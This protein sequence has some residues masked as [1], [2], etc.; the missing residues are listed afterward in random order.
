[1]PAILEPAAVSR[2]LDP[3]AAGAEPLLALLRPYAAE[4]L[5]VYPVSPRVNQVTYDQPDCVIA[6]PEEGNLS[7]FP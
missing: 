3:N 7:L 5:V 4:D 6:V 2:W 1:M